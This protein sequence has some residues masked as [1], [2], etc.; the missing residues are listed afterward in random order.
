MHMLSTI[1]RGSEK[2]LFG[3]FCIVA[4]FELLPIIY[5]KS[6]F[7]M[8]IGTFDVKNLEALTACVGVLF[9]F[10]ISFYIGRMALVT[11][12][13]D[14]FLAA[15]L[16]KLTAFLKAHPIELNVRSLQRIL[17]NRGEIYNF[18]KTSVF[19][20]MLEIPFAI[21]YILVLWILNPKFAIVTSVIFVGG[22]VYVWFSMK[23]IRVY[24]NNAVRKNED[25]AIGISILSNSREL[26]L[27]NGCMD[28]MIKHWHADFQAAQAGNYIA[29]KTQ[30]N[31]SAVIR[32][33]VFFTGSLLLT[34]G[35][36]EFVNSESDLADGAFLIIGK[37][38]GMLAIKSLLTFCQI[39]KPTI[40][41]F[42]AMKTSQNLVDD[43]TKADLSDA[44]PILGFPNGKLQINHLFSEI[45]SKKTGKPVINNI[46]FDLSPGQM[47]CIVGGAGVGK[48]FLCNY[49]AGYAAPFRGSV[50][51]QGIPVE[52][53]LRSKQNRCIG[54]AP[55]G[56]LPIAGS[57]V[58][59][60][61]QSGLPL[62]EDRL[63]TCLT[64]TGLLEEIDD[65]SIPAVALSLGQ[66][67]RLSIARVLYQNPFVVIADA[68]ETGLDGHNLKLM[69]RLFQEL[70][71]LNRIVIVSTNAKELAKTADLWLELS[72]SEFQ[73][74]QNPSPE[75]A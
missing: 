28:G 71:A 51:L 18:L 70:R 14:R 49:L 27:N 33:L 13:S 43:S 35:A 22:L 67:A 19:T 16:N 26:L 56:W 37:L 46:F 3:L 31:V 40:D 5:L 44:Y 47:L 10:A 66:R 20:Q 24:E 4:V 72:P 7:A 61:I 34:I 63:E 54:Y 17:D 30:A 73:L 60:E 15:N 50:N 8:V 9:L 1:F 58:I 6:V 21:F 48:S 42:E 38:L 45:H 12:H 69:S 53:W 39:W 55:Q 68:P 52:A 2:L 23:K 25:A 59:E 29:K 41:A 11:K 62:D 64:K 57:S 75:L 36:L 32:V 65:L 74:R